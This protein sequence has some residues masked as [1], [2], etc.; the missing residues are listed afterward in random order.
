MRATAKIGMQNI[1]H[2]S[3]RH[4]EH[5]SLTLLQREPEKVSWAALSSN[6]LRRIH[7]FFKIIFSDRLYCLFGFV[8]S[9]HERWI[10]H[11]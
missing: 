6:V 7:N 10:G 8:F 11:D 9:K 2:A 1:P 4:T 3:S 5:A